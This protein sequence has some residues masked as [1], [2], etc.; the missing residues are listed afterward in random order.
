ML[1]H[2]FCKSV[3]LSEGARANIFSQCTID[4][5]CPWDEYL[6]D[7]YDEINPNGFISLAYSENKLIWPYIKEW[8]QKPLSQVE[9]QYDYTFG[10]SLLREGLLFCGRCND[11]LTFFVKEC[12]VCCEKL[13]P[14][15]C[16]NT[17]LEHLTFCL[18]DPGAKIALLTPC[19]PQH[20]VALTYRNQMQIVEVNEFSKLLKAVA[21]REVLGVV[22]TNPS[23]PCG[24]V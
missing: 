8:F 22:W 10:G 5:V 11:C 3:T 12:A 23:N 17:I 6:K 13:V 24:T 14:K 18:F 9:S 19:Y 2:L 7:P 20:R 4:K 1:L 16:R 15:S 21:A